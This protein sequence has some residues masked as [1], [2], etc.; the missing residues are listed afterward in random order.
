MVVGFLGLPERPLELAREIH[1]QY[2]DQRFT[3]KIGIHHGLVFPYQDINGR[4]N[5]A[6]SSINMA[7]RVESCCEP[8]HILVA[9]PPA[10]ALQDLAEWNRYLHGPPYTF[11]AKRSKEIRAYNFYEESEGVGNPSE[12]LGPARVFDTKFTTLAEALGRLG[13]VPHESL[14]YPDMQTVLGDHLAIDDAIL[15]IPLRGFA[16][17]PA[18]DVISE[19]IDTPPLLPRQVSEAKATIPEPAPNRRKIYL[20]STSEPVSDTGDLLTLTLGPT[21]YWNA[22]AIEQALASVHGSIA[23]GELS[24]FNFPRQLNCHILVVTADGKLILARRAS[25]PTV[26][27]RPLQWGATIGESIDAQRDLDDRSRISVAKTVEKALGQSEELGL[28]N[29]DINNASVKFVALATEWQF[30]ISV[31]VAVVR[32]WRTQSTAVREYCRLVARDRSEISALDWI[33][34]TIPTALPLVITGYHT[35]VQAR[36]TADHMYGTSRLA[37]LA[38]LC[39]EFGYGA[40]TRAVQAI[41]EQ[42]KAAQSGSRGV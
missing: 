34:F 30:M 12:P 18:S 32:L 33:D 35:P 22:L 10:V 9:Q 41:S 36:E 25:F 26:R 3:L 1:Q 38:A 17:V 37:I 2:G 24:L 21:E 42:K 27:Y 28:P 4:S 40:V 7:Q 29:E 39:S 23:A 15:D 19:M 20:A 6:G 16:G 13:V 14:R 5:Y 11:R 8:G 31:L